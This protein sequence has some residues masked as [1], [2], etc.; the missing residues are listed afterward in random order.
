MRAPSLSGRSD[1][2]S[3]TWWVQ[4]ALS[5]YDPGASLRSCSR[6]T[7]LKIRRWRRPREEDWEKKTENI[8]EAMGH[9]QSEEYAGTAESKQMSRGN[10]A[11]WKLYSYP[12]FIWIIHE[13]MVTRRAEG[14]SIY[15]PVIQAWLVSRSETLRSEHAREWKAT[16]DT[17]IIQTI[18]LITVMKAFLWDV[19]VHRRSWNSPLEMINKRNFSAWH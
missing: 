6:Q 13:R 16:W 11:T 4:P 14:R 17:S 18:V 8:K 10:K 2:T 19:V 7:G 9:S 12:V 1:S 5:S 15:Y 3:K